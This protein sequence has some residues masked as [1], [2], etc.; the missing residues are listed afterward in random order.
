MTD[1][2]GRERNINPRAVITPASLGARK[3]P[4][5]LIEENS[6]E[7]RSAQSSSGGERPMQNDDA[8]NASVGKMS[9]LIPNLNVPVC[10]GTH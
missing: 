6:E 1:I 7:S 3:Q 4:T 2:S 8:S 5:T 10:N 9:A